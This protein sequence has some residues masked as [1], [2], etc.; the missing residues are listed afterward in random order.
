MKPAPA[1]TIR[2][3]LA[4][5]IALGEKKVETRPWTTRHRGEILI[6]AG[7]GAHLLPGWG[8]L[9]LGGFNGAAAVMPRIRRDVLVQRGYA[10]QLQWGRGCDA[11]D[12]SRARVQR[13]P[14]HPR[15]NG[16]AAVMPRIRRP[17]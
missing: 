10:H 4:S 15:F 17:S 1:L 8:V 7:K 12:T 14:F 6:H 5:L 16:A 3:P 9:P 11:A 2:Q 13:A